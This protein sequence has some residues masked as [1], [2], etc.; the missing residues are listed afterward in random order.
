MNFC[1]SCVEKRG[2]QAILGVKVILVSKD[3]GSFMPK[4]DVVGTE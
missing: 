2:A 1:R 3:R 4:E